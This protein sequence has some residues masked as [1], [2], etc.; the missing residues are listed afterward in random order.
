MNYTKKQRQSQRQRQSKKGYFESSRM[1]GSYEADKS[2]KKESM[3][4]RL[5]KMF[6]KEVA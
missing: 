3:L 5:R 6:G 2:R 1:K 4:S